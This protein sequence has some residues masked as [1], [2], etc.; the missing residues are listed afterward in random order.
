MMRCPACN[1]QL[2]VDKGRQFIYCQ[3]CGQQIFLDDEVRRT[4]STINKNVTIR[5]IDEAKLREAEL[6]E[7][8]LYR[9]EKKS[10][11]KKKRR[12]I[13]LLIIAALVVF[14]MVKGRFE[15]L[16]EKA[17]SDKVEK[18]VL[19]ACKD[20]DATLDRVSVSY[21]YIYVDV[22]AAG[23]QRELVDRLQH[24]I[25]D[26]FP[27][28]D[29]YTLSLSIYYPEHDRIREISMN[30][31]GQ[32]DIKWDDTNS[33]SEEETAE[34]VESVKK[35]LPGI[36]KDTPLALKEVSYKGD[37]A[38]IELESDTMEKATIDEILTDIQAA[39]EEL[40]CPD[41]ELFVT[42]DEIDTL[43]SEEIRNGR[44]SVRS[45]YRNTITD[46]EAQKLEEEYRKAVSSACRKAGAS[47]TEIV[48]KEDTLYIRIRMSDKSKKTADKIERE[49]E[50]ATDGL[51]PLAMDV[52]ITT[53]NLY[54]TVRDYTV[55]EKGNYDR[56]LDFSE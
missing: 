50:S 24:D 38:I 41:M 5:K 30:E 51:T 33:L 40:G 8:E 48:L 34:I 6:K 11:A 28:K 26:D 36:L 4:E 3:Y 42:S 46:E 32:V 54:E 10:I 1:A 27:M 35:A 20:N 56:G 31:Y 29:E 17:Y 18:H 53:E 16:R 45:D 52:S 43:V 21:R 19:A 39:V 2:N 9:K 15:D 49:I 7:Q 44:I 22:R 55:D 25:V 37:A 12:R 14:G 23:S 13:I 47:L